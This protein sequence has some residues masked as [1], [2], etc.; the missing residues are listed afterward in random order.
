MNSINN[1]SKIL[2]AIKI[3][4]REDKKDENL[5]TCIQL[6]TLVNNG[7]STKDLLAVVE[8]HLEQIKG[9]DPKQEF[10]EQAFSAIDAIQPF[11]TTT[12]RVIQDALMEIKQL[13][14]SSTPSNYFTAQNQLFTQHDQ[15]QQINELADNL[16][17]NTLSPNALDTKLVNLAARYAKSKPVVATPTK[18]IELPVIS[19]RSNSVPRGLDNSGN[20]CFMN[21]LSQVV[22][23]SPRCSNALGKHPDKNTA[24]AFKNFSGAYDQSNNLQNANEKFINTIRKQHASAINIAPRGQGSAPELFVKLFENDKNILCKVGHVGDLPSPKNPGYD[25]FN[26][27]STAKGNDA[28][29]V[30]A[31][32]AMPIDDF[33]KFRD[34]VSS[35]LDQ[36]YSALFYK[37]VAQHTSL[38]Q[39]LAELKK[40]NPSNSTQIAK[41]NKKIDD[42]VYS[43]DDV[44]KGLKNEPVIGDKPKLTLLNELISSQKFTQFVNPHKLLF[45]DTS[46]YGIDDFNQLVQKLDF[47]AIPEYQSLSSLMIH[48]GAEATGGHYEA[49]VKK[50]ALW[51]YCNDE[52]VTLV[53]S[54]EKMAQQI[55][56]L[57]TEADGKIAAYCY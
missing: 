33:T 7:A 2:G 51:Y 35:N 31:I 47:K 14:S 5:T 32:T 45:V 30:N 39:E 24:T 9:D 44:A 46:S 25:F 19:S 42:N 54:D 12:P 55:E 3:A 23:N 49:Y 6:S 48:H 38:A 29:L 20:N 21:T 52:N 1:N 26:A 16:A 36:K 22:K 17:N 15:R 34:F 28:N 18:A 10:L 50:D 37:N 43:F 4:H 57:N 56:K 13:M 8:K 40:N 41:L 53:G 27:L 11:G